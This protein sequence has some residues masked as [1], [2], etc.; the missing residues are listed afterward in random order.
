MSDNDSRK[1]L[2]IVGAS[3]FGREVASW[4]QRDKSLMFNYF[5]A[6]FLDDDKETMKDHSHYLEKIISGIEDYEVRSTD[7]LL[8]AL[9]EPSAKIRVSKLLEGRGGCF[10]TF[11]DPSVK[12]AKYVSIGRGSILCPN[13]VVSCDAN[14]G[15]FVTVNLG[16]SVGHD[17]KI[18][19]GSTLS[20]HSDVTG[21]VKL[22]EG[23]FLGSHASV[24]PKVEVGDFARIG[25]GSVV[26]RR[27]K[28]HSSVMGVPATKIA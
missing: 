4:I 24:L 12:I 13:C 7:L 21:C 6:G 22:G 1:R 10:A 9:S 5:L 14:I 17:V 3:S 11:I 8:M 15:A 23:V 16:C 28:S 2:I 20:S 27:L 18:G 19:D 25:A 26:V